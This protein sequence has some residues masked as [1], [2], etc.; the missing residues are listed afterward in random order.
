MS[1]FTTPAK[2]EMLDHYKWRLVEQFI[3]YTEEICTYLPMVADIDDSMYL[4][5]IINVPKGY[6]TDLT[7]VPRLL[8]SVFPTW[9]IVAKQFTSTLRISPLGRR[10]VA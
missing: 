10:S 5:H 1:Q 6:V 2:L 7:S 9:P 3:Y 8:W 4:C